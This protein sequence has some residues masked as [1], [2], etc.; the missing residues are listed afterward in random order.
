MTCK[1]NFI[2]DFVGRFG[3]RGFLTLIELFTMFPHQE[4]CART[5][6]EE[7]GT[8][9]SRGV[10]LHTVLWWGNIVN[11]KLPRGGRVLSINLVLKAEIMG[12]VV[13]FKWRISDLFPKYVGG[14]S[15]FCSKLNCF[16]DV[17]CVLFLVCLI[18]IYL[19]M[20]ISTSK[21]Y[22][23]SAFE[24]GYLRVSP[25]LRLHLCAFRLYSEG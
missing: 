4:P 24:P 1:G 22:C 10:L 17:C 15:W 7:P 2:I 5:T 9:P 13:K 11:R 21:P 25:V 19:C 12:G 3:G 23:G 6:L 16:T 14:L 20:R 8:N 18:S